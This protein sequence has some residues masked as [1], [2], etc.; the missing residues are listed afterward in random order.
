MRI[1][2]SYSSHERAEAIAVQSWLEK[3]GWENDVFVDVDPEHGLTGGESWRIALRDAAG[4]CEAVILLLSRAWLESKPCWNEFQL[5]EKYGKP[6]I[7]VRVDDAVLIRDLPREITNNYQIIEK[8]AAPPAEFEMRLKR[9]LEA[10]GAGPENFALP[11]GRRP[12]PGLEALNELDAALLFG[13]D[14]DV[15]AALDTLREIRSTG[16]KRLF[17]LLGASGA[18][19]SSLMRAGIW[20]R[21]NRDDRNFI[22]LPTVRPSNAILTGKEGLWHALETGMADQRRARHLPA[23][24]PRT[25]AAIR[26][27]AENDTGALARLFTDMKHA[28]QQSFLDKTAAAPSIVLAIDQ[29]EELF[30]PEGAAEVELFLRLL[31]SVW[32]GDPQF[33]ALIAIRSDVYPRLQADSRIDQQQ[34]RPFNLAPMAPAGLLQVIEGPA[35]RIGLQVEPAL[36]AGLLRDSQGADALP[37]LAFTLERL[38][39]ERLQ[40]KRL[41]LDD[42]VRMGGVRGAIEAA[43]GKARAAAVAAGMP[44]QEL[45]TLLRRTFLPHLARIN[46]AGEFARRVAEFS[47]LDRDCLPL[48][49]VLVAQRLLIADQRGEVKTVEIA[50]EAILREWPLLRGWLDAERGFLEWREQ[51]GR[52]RRLHERNEGDLLSGRA[53][54]VAHAFLEARRDAIREP[55]RQFIEASIAAETKRVEAEEAVREAHRQAELNAAKVSEEAALAAAAAEKKLA[56]AARRTTSRVRGFA[57]VMT[58]LAMVATAAGYLA[59]VNSRAATAEAERATAAAELEKA[60]R[61]AANLARLE[62]ESRRVALVSEAVRADSGDDKA[63]ALAWLAVPHDAEMKSRPLT[64]EA[65]SAV[66]LRNAQL[67]GSL[68]NPLDTIVAPEGNLAVTVFADGSAELWDMKAREVL[69]KFTDLKTDFDTDDEAKK[70]IRYRGF[71][72]SSL[73]LFF[74]QNGNVLVTV[75]GDDVVRSWDLTSSSPTPKSELPLQ[76]HMIERVVFS[77]DGGFLFGLTKDNSGLVWQLATGKQV[78]NIRKRKLIDGA[79]SEDRAYFFGFADPNS[80]TV[81]RL[82]DGRELF[83]LPPTKDKTDYPYYFDTGDVYFSQASNRLLTTTASRGREAALWDLR[84]GRPIGKLVTEDGT[85]GFGDQFEFM[86]ID[87]GKLIL[88]GAEQGG[89]GWLWNAATGKLVRRID[90][91]AGVARKEGQEKILRLVDGKVLISGLDGQEEFRFGRGFNINQVSELEVDFETNSALAGGRNHEGQLE[92]WDIKADFLRSSLGRISAGA[93][94][95]GF[96]LSPD[97]SE[98][99]TEN[100]DGIT[101]LW[102]TR[103]GALLATLVPPNEKLAIDEARFSPDGG[104]VL[105]ELKED[106]DYGSKLVETQVWAL[107]GVRKLQLGLPA[108]SA[109]FS[110]DG[111]R[112]LITAEDHSAKIWLAKGKNLLTELKGHTGTIVNAAF[113]GDG[114]RVITGA[115]DNT[116][117]IWD[118]AT[119]APR[120]TLAGHASGVSRVAFSRDGKLALTASHDSTA[121]VWD[122]QTAAVK[123]T[124]AGHRGSILAASFSPDGTRVLT[125]S[126]DETAIVWSVETGERVATLAGHT[127]AVFSARFSPDG[128]RVLT[129]SEDHT[130]R[131]WDA[132]SGSPLATLDAHGGPVND[133]HWSPNG[134]GILTVSGDKSGI[135]WDASTFRPRMTL[136][137]HL[138]PVTRA[139]FSPDGNQAA[140]ISDDRTLRLWDVETGALLATYAGHNKT[141]HALAFNRDGRVIA[142]VSS[143]GSAR[144][145]TVFPGKLTARVAE[146]GAMV[147]GRSPLTKD[148]CEQHDVVGLPGADVACLAE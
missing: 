49:T 11:A 136:K 118:A 148:E 142:T 133:A 144:L 56:D 81:W 5:A 90:G 10:A 38:F 32:E 91:Y 109:T 108:R 96:Q 116:A 62:S 147:A 68:K 75:H 74:L 18:G 69:R 78:L 130:A 42:Y 46:D 76:K 104:S 107:R 27:A 85:G 12:Y 33:I 25:R 60:A 45:D 7:P 34:V 103:S 43:A 126:T 102:N 52:A 40:D 120:S 50:H 111:S 99:L 35:R 24:T 61:S 93:E 53:L 1:F 113:S 89:I 131:V 146:V 112:I 57:V 15:L 36:T 29:G 20:P 55:D 70:G 58:L 22:V 94:G 79:F 17:A 138:G 84:T 44:A 66:Y 100:A 125:A 106:A 31:N 110:P 134:S 86:F 16:R 6:C 88:I 129:S 117:K 128:S 19:K 14:A 92:L 2:I 37:L 139:A 137:S 72:R 73:P 124:F 97:G 30:N 26:L 135:L 13:R 140:T 48:V 71:A 115:W 98:I 121:K 23:E 4:R 122:A 127:G 67:I 28:A 145:W 80:G 87:N 95:A 41:A 77:S 47:E 54:A 119:G 51:I 105:V 3:N 82:D 83:T 143:D 114:A 59:F 141:I 8:A 101:R 63:L 123:K 39:D 132:A 64:H 65:A 21:L 9:A